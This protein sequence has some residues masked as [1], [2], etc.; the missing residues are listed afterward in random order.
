VPSYKVEPDLLYRLG[1]PH[2]QALKVAYRS[3]IAGYLSASRR[4]SK[5][6]RQYDASVLSQYDWIGTNARTRKSKDRRALDLH[7][8]VSQHGTETTYA[9]RQ[10]QNRADFWSGV[11]KFSTHRGPPDG[12]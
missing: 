4:L 6:N 9:P 1:S 11:G 12:S 10:S 5:L 8:G 7:V 3:F 2:N